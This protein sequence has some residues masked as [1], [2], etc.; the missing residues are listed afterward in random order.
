MRPARAV[1]D[2]VTFTV[3]ATGGILFSHPVDGGL[4]TAKIGGSLEEEMN[5]NS[6]DPNCLTFC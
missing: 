3:D 2:N 1:R 4:L 5:K 6:Q